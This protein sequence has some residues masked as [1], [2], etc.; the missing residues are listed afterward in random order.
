MPFLT[1]RNKEH[2]CWVC[3]CHRKG[4]VEGGCSWE[5]HGAGAGRGCLSFQLQTGTTLIIPALALAAMGHLAPQPWQS[6]DGLFCR[7][8]HQLPS[9]AAWFACTLQLLQKKMPRTEGESVQT[10]GDTARFG[11]AGQLSGSSLSGFKGSERMGLAKGL[12]AAC[13]SLEKP[14]LLCHRSLREEGQSYKN[15]S[16]VWRGEGKQ[17]TVYLVGLFIFLKHI[18]QR[19]LLTLLYIRGVQPRTPICACGVSIP[20]MTAGVSLTQSTFNLLNQRAKNN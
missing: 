19:K 14:C 11:L 2:S 9:A 13:I 3:F 5:L 17:A 18:R 12:S 1:V 7:S 8:G 6:S 15:L 16:L 4:S 20:L 10:R